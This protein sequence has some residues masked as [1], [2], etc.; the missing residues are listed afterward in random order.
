MQYAIPVAAMAALVVSVIAALG[1][2]AA[3]ALFAGA[4]TVARAEDV[5]ESLSPRA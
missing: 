1:L 2:V 3:T 5:S 4:L